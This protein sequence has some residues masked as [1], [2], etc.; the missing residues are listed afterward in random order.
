MVAKVT[1]F[2][3]EISFDTSKPDGTKRKL[4]DV[5]RL[6]KM[7]WSASVALEDGLRETYAWFLENQRELREA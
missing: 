6:S 1:G 3:G 7:G 5:S 2:E 4:M